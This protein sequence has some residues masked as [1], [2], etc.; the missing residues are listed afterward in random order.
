MCGSVLHNQLNV[1]IRL[2]YQEYL[3]TMINCCTYNFI[4]LVKLKSLTYFISFLSD[5]SF[6]PFF[7][8]PPLLDQHQELCGNGGV[9]VLIQAI[10]NLKASSSDSTSLYSAA[11]SRLKSKA[12]SIVS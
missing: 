3:D 12:L 4:S 9:L 1:C 6:S 7:S 2:L 11:I 5:H 10:M 8:S